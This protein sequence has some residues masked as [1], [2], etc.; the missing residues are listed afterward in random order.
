[1]SFSALRAG[2]RAVRA[3]VI[4][5]AAIGVAMVTGCGGGSSTPSLTSGPIVILTTLEAT[6][7][8]PLRSGL[9][10]GQSVSQRFDEQSC[11]YQQYTNEKARGQYAPLGCDQP[12]TPRQLVLSV[13]P[14]IG[15]NQPC[16]VT[17]VQ[18]SPGIVLFTKTGPGDPANGGAPN[19]FC[20]VGVKDPTLP[21]G[22]N[23]VGFYL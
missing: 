9:A 23:S 19:F 11:R 2:T 17:A 18:T 12:V 10:P 15:S 20:N 6:N 21:P 13:A 14:M 5:A 16:P 7:F 3:I 8:T 4:G 1:M 22:G